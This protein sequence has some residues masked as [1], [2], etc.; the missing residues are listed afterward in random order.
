MRGEFVSAVKTRCASAHSGS[1]RRCLGRTADA[2]AAKIHR[3]PSLQPASGG[4]GAVGAVVFVSEPAA[5]VG[6]P[7]SLSVMGCSGA[8]KRP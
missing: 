3:S 1:G 7:L 5:G 4:F 6:F 8:R 2:R